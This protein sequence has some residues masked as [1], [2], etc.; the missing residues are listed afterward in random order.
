MVD[1]G[2]SRVIAFDPLEASHARAREHGVEIG[3]MER[4]MAEARRRRRHHR[5]APA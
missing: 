2:V 3:S 5:P 1:A 4:V